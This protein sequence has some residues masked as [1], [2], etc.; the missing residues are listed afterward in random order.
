ML[1]AEHEIIHVLMPLFDRGMRI[2]MPFPLSDA[3]AVSRIERRMSRDMSVA[4]K[5]VEIN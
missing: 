4:L 5:D 3:E 2:D 1:K